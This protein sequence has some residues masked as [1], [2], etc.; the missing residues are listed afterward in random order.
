MPFSQNNAKFLKRRKYFDS[1]SEVYSCKHS[2]DLET[3]KVFESKEQDLS[4][5]V[6]E[7]KGLLTLKNQQKKSKSMTD[8]TSSVESEKP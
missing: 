6:S 1:S 7:E 3:K 8:L 2:F 4:H 5:L